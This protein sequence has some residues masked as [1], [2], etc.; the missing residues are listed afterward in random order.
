MSFPTK[1]LSLRINS[2]R[3]PA[4]PGMQFGSHLRPYASI[5]RTEEII[6]LRAVTLRY[7]HYRF[8]YLPPRHA[9]KHDNRRRFAIAMRGQTLP[10]PASLNPTFIAFSLSGASSFRSILG[11]GFFCQA[12]QKEQARIHVAGDVGKK[13]GYQVPGCV[14][15][16]AYEDSVG[17]GSNSLLPFRME[18]SF[19]H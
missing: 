7:F 16:D 14:G 5:C 10:R 13:L 1:C 4:Q 18:C 15:T 6:T 8:D 3:T 2:L 19:Q 9:T 11:G 17:A 12:A